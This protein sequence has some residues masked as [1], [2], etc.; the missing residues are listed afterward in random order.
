MTTK[1]VYPQGLAEQ[2]PVQCRI[3]IHKRLN[4]MKELIDKGGDVASDGSVTK[5]VGAL[6]DGGKQ[7]VDRK[8]VV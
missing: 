4:R 5:V 8:S 6:V 1:Y 2:H 3:S 7:V